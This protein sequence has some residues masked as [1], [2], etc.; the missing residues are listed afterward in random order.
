MASGGKPYTMV[1][2]DLDRFKL[3]NDTHG[4]ATGDA[5][6]RVFAEVLRASVRNSDIAGRWGGEEFTIV[7]DNRHA[8]S[9]LEAVDQ[10]RKNLSARLKLGK[11]PVF[12]A[13]SGIADSSMP[14]Q[15]DDLIKLADLALY[16]AKANG[17]H[18]A[19]VADA[20]PQ[21]APPIARR[22]EM[23]GAGREAA[24]V[25]ANGSWPHAGDRPVDIRA[26]SDSGNAHAV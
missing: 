3:L 23:S 21:E 14:H 7:F 18:R 24:A 1:M 15:S 9:A 26:T 6:L 17:R 12:T 16:E 5:A 25:A 10:L 22:A 8:A 2:C 20:S 19:C 13:S 11:T 4:H